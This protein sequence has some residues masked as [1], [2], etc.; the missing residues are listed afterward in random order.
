MTDK[1]KE[2]NLDELKEKVTKA[3]EIAGS[4]CKELRQIAKDFHKEQ[5]TINVAF[6]KNLAKLYGKTLD[7]V[8]AEVKPAKEE[9][10]VK[11][12]APAKAT[13]RKRT[14]GKSKK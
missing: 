4:V 6:F 14:P 10:K 13:Q 2:L 1:I 8:E 9:K 12:A 5:K 7:A 3:R 11:K